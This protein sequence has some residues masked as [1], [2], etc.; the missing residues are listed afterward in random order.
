MIED[1]C[2]PDILDDEALKIYNEPGIVS[3]ETPSGSLKMLPE[4]WE[5]ILKK[6]KKL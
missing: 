5:R 1:E 3:L 6:L 2:K 4:D